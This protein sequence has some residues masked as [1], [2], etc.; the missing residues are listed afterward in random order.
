MLIEKADVLTPSGTSANINLTQ[1]F[2]EA[3][4]FIMGGGISWYIAVLSMDN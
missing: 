1:N 4:E 3:A 2:N